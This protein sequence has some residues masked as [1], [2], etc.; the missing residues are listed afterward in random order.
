MGKGYYSKN[1]CGDFKHRA[2][3]LVIRMNG[4]TTREA[5]LK[6]RNSLDQLFR[7]ELEYHK[8]LLPDIFKI[9][10]IMVSEEWLESILYNNELYLVVSEY[11]G[12]IV[13]AILYKVEKNPDDSL[14]KDRKYGYIEEMIV[15]EIYRE[16]GIGK[17]L[18]DYAIK[19]FQTKYLK[20]IEIDVWEKNKTGLKFYEDHGF[21]TIRRRMKTEIE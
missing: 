6:D 16:K 12:R 17:Q 7:E 18:L 2:I 3:S 10:E 13:G 1:L 20:E 14:L 9:P 15:S 21:K 11:E 19:D 5:E 4:M 8:S